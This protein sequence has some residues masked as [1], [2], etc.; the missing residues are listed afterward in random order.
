MIEASLV[1]FP[2]SLRYGGQAGFGFALRFWFLVSGFK[3]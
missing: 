1:G 3:K 2:T